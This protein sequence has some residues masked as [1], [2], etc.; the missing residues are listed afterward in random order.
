MRFSKSFQKPFLQCPGSVKLAI[1]KYSAVRP[2]NF[3]QSSQFTVLPELDH[4]KVRLLKYVAASWTH[5]C[6]RLTAG[7]CRFRRRL[8]GLTTN[9]RCRADAADATPWTPRTPR[10][11]RHRADARKEP[12]VRPA[13]LY[14]RPPRSLF[15]Q[16]RDLLYG[17]DSATYVAWLQQRKKDY[18]IES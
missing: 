9:S 17:S 13:E 14:E 4:T 15:V 1:R 16:S 2:Y 11:G 8:A 10:R 3:L 7:C 18:M 6:S 5:G 12:D